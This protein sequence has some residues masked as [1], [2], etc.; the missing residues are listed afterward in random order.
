MGTRGGEMTTRDS[1][2]ARAIISSHQMDVPVMLM[3][4]AEGLGV[5]VYK[6]DFGRSEDVSGQMVLDPRDGS[7][8][9]YSITANAAH[10]LARRRYTIAHLLGHFILHGHILGEGVLAPERYFCFGGMSLEDEAN[11]FA[12][13]TLVPRHLLR[14]G[15]GKHGLLVRRLAGVFEVPVNL[16]AIR[17]DIPYDTD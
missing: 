8:S 3:P 14:A 11:K 17:M 15:V 12:M 9:G 4:I 1:A 2:H 13:E 10:P 7:K 6:G 16:M 5:K